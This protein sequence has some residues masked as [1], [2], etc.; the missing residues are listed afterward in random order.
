MA[1]WSV[2]GL[3]FEWKYCISRTAAV[4]TATLQSCG[5]RLARD[6]GGAMD[7]RVWV[8]G[9]YRDRPRRP[10]GTSG[11]P[12]VAIGVVVIWVWGAGDTKGSPSETG[13]WTPPLWLWIVIGTA[14]VLV[15]GALSV[16]LWKRVRR[17]NAQLLAAEEARAAERALAEQQLADLKQV[18]PLATLLELNREQ[19]DQYHRIAT[20]QADMSF[21]SSQRAMW[22]G[23]LVVVSCVAGGVY[24]KGADVKIFMGAIALVG[25]SLS[26]FLN[27][28]YLRMYGQTLSQLNRYFEQPV[29]TGYYLTAERLAED[30][31]PRAKDEVRRQIITQVLGASN[32]LAKGE[33][34]ARG[35]RHRP[36]RAR[37][38]TV[39]GAEQPAPLSD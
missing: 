24:L 6:G 14:F 3:W 32:R 20:D 22:L 1:T 11:W 27:R 26:A 36:R 21:R 37:K 7:S 30:L 12:V 17:E 35:R 2:V 16:Y 34:G 13:A 29:L 31:E 28:T 9:H 23:L 5:E 4:H 15:A 39:D 25:A 38:E 18:T 33:P 8:Q 19:I 10:S